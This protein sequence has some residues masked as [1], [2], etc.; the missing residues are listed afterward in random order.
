MI[1]GVAVVVFGIF[2]VYL[3]IDGAKRFRLSENTQE[4]TGQVQSITEAGRVPPLVAVH[5]PASLHG[6]LATCRALWATIPLR[7]RP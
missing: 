1:G 3:R 6:P 2:L 7:I 5:G 4:I